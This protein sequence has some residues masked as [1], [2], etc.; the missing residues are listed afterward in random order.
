MIVDDTRMSDDL[1]L[2]LDFLRS[3]GTDAKPVP[4]LTILYHPDSERIGEFSVLP[5][6]LRGQAVDIARNTLDFF[7]YRGSVGRSLND[8][9]LSRKPLFIEPADGRYILKNSTGGSS[10]RVAGINATD[11][12][13]SFETASLTRGVCLVIAERVVLLLH[14]SQAGFGKGESAGY[15]LIGGC[16]AIKSVRQSIEQCSQLEADVLIVGESGTGKELV[17]Q[18]IHQQSKRSKAELVSVNMAAIPVSLAAAELF[19]S[20]KGSYTGAEQNRLG[21]IRQ[22]QGGT[23]FL[24]EIGD[25]PQELQPQLFRVLESREVQPVGGSPC[26]INVRFISAAD[27][28]LN[29]SG[30]RK[31]L[32]HRLGSYEIHMPPL[33]DR[34]GD[35]ARL[36][37]HFLNSE[38]RNLGMPTRLADDGG[39]PV[40]A[41]GWVGV[42]EQLCVHSWPGNVRELRNIVRQLAINNQGRN[43]VTIPA[44]MLKILAAGDSIDTGESNNPLRRYTDVS[45]SELKQAMEQAEWEIR[46]AADLLKVSRQSI[47]KLIDKDPDLRTAGDIPAEE[48]Q[49]CYRDCHGDLL[50]MRDQL[51]VSLPALRR[52]LREFK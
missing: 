45:G 42:F 14:V 12:T 29:T 51:K 11:A 24:D 34:Q 32:W 10:V 27:A 35:I 3:S 8:P 31:A 21:Y 15:S 30:F 41:H 38:Y 43:A 26:K 16:D 37:K 25:T 6:L 48:L 36:L 1:T 5:Q 50:A 9:Y 40:L 7:Q 17:A 46:L 47:Y 52:R 2:S 33:R 19:G 22:A 28:E 39:N 13:Y 49:T 44:H 4:T 20:I 18:A 23:L